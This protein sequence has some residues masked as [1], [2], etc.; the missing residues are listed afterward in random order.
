VP[1]IVDCTT[2]YND[3]AGIGGGNLLHLRELIHEKTR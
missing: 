3:L 2:M 1:L